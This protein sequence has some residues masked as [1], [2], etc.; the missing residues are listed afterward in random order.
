MTVNVKLSSGKCSLAPST[1]HVDAT[2]NTTSVEAHVGEQVLHLV[3]RPPQ[4][5]LD[6]PLLPNALDTVVL[7]LDGGYEVKKLG[8][9]CAA[10]SGVASPHSDLDFLCGAEIGEATL[11]LK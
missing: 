1:R 6:A 5:G 11:L 3:E 8:H 2:W 4:R 10:V 9:A 7:V